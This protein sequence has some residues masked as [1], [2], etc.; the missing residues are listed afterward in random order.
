MKPDDHRFEKGCLFASLFFDVC[1]FAFG[2]YMDHHTFE[3]WN[4]VPVMLGLCFMAIFCLILSIP[5]WK[6]FSL[7]S[8]TPV[9]LSQTKSA[10]AS[11]TRT[12]T[13]GREEEFRR[14]LADV[15]V[16]AWR[17]YQQYESNIH[18]AWLFQKPH[19]MRNIMRRCIEKAL[20]ERVAYSYPNNPWFIPTEQNEDKSLHWEYATRLPPFLLAESGYRAIMN[21]IPDLST[22]FHWDF[23]SACAKTD[24]YRK[25]MPE[26]EDPETKMVKRPVWNDEDQSWHVQDMP[27]S[28][29]G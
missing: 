23:A 9:S 26:R 11:P 5:S 28:R 1:I 8:K 19:F 13:T 14:F 25:A 20:M 2:K 3:S 24:I 12:F 18:A 27:R 22:C 7:A 4:P 15:Y 17:Q 16:L 29:G 6:D 10:S 21:E